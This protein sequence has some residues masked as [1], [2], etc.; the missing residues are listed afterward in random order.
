MA[1]K[2]WQ[3]SAQLANDLWTLTVSGTIVSQTY[4]VT[5]NGKSLS[6]AAGGSDTAT[7][8]YAAFVTLWNSTAVPAPPEFK[9]LIAT[10]DASGLYLNGTKSGVPHTISITTGGAA[11]VA[12]TNTTV[13][14]GPNSFA[15]GANWS[16]GVAPA[17]SDVLVYDSGN[18]PCLY[19]LA[20]I[21]TGVTVI[22]S[23]N[24]TGQIGLPDI[25]T[26]SPSGQYFE[27]RTKYLTLAGGTANINAPKV[28]LCRIA[29]GAHLYTAEILNSGPGTNGTPA[30]LM[31]G[32][33]SSSNCYVVKGTLG[34]A[35]LAGETGSLA[36]LSLAYSGNQATDA[37]V[38]CG[39]GMTLVTVNKSGGILVLNSGATTLSQWLTGGTVTTLGSAAFTTINLNGGTGFLNATGTIATLNVANDGVA[40]FAT[41]PQGKTISNAI[42]VFGS[43]AQV[44]DPSKVVNSGVL[45]VITVGT[46]LK[47][48]DHGVS[49]T[50]S[51]M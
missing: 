22:V 40:N 16:G 48:L 49:N 50:I 12:A 51:L 26:S 36:L 4:A 38:T 46:P 9:E 10:S 8:I 20:T 42:N 14:T 7:I 29:W 30:I 41:D 1:T 31:T 44:L 39:S 32:G 25:N 11:T 17:N 28:N 37:N 2:R 47:N 21:L 18:V 5:I 3:G 33:N 23:Q 15:N 35:I 19:D 43:I 34:L 45:S 27:Y 13:G 24:Y 6:Y